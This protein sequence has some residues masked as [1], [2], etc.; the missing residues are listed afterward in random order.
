MVSQPGISRLV[1]FWFI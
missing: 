1:S